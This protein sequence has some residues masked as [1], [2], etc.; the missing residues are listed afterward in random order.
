MALQQI[1]GN[2][3]IRAAA[4]F[5]AQGAQGYDA[6]SA[7]IAS[8]TNVADAAKIAQSGYNTALDNAKGSLR[9]PPNHYRQ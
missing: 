6:L 9:V 7:S 5:A 8:Q 4:V 1:F 2:D 3:G